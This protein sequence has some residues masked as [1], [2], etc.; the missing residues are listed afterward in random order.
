MEH[1]D[2]AGEHFKNSKDYPSYGDNVDL[3]SNT[4]FEVLMDNYIECNLYRMPETIIKKIKL[5]QSVL[6]NYEQNVCVRFGGIEQADA[7]RGLELF[8]KEVVPELRTG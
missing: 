6:G 3:Y 8:M 1:Y 7:K 2:L 4:N 5:R